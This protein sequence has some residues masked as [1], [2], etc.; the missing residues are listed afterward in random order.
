[1]IPTRHIEL[2][3]NLNR[4]FPTAPI[5]AFIGIGTIG[6]NIAR[7]SS[8][9]RIGAH[10]EQTERSGT[11]YNFIAPSRHGKGIALSI[12]TKIASHVEGIRNQEYITRLNAE[13]R[14]DHEGHPIPRKVIAERCS[15]VRPHVIF[16]TGA[17]GLQTQATAASNAGCGVIMVPEIKCGK[18]RYTEADGSYSPLL[19]F[20]DEHI[21]ANTYRK[22]DHIP[23]IKN[24][25]IQVLAAGVIGFNL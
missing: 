17:N 14:Q 12:V 21:P 2:F 18:G 4:A 10:Q 24:C 3:T 1:M 6:T 20:Y 5:F 23:A 22:A 16:L 15:I 9:R 7:F 13:P 25:R 11:F 19:S 8:I